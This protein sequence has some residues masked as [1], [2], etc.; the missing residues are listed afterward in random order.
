MAKFAIK[1]VS[2]PTISRTR[3]VYVMFDEG[4]EELEA[5]AVF[6][7]LSQVM[8]AAGTPAHMKVT[9]FSVWRNANW[10]DGDGYLTEWNS[11]DWYIAYTKEQSRE[12]QLHGGTLLRLLYSE[13]WQ[14]ADPHYDIVV[15]SRD[16]YDDDCHFCIGLAIRGFGTIISTNRFRGLSMQDAYNCIVTETMHE[17]GHVFGLVAE[18]RKS[19]VERSLGL[20]CTNR[21]IMR[22]GLRVPYDWQAITA[23]RLEGHEFCGECAHD[24]KRYFH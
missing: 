20:H 14:E 9:N 13:P 21:C 22:Q 15:T 24:L 8:I 19:N 11:V 16:L 5:Q 12:G 3:P 6:D 18:T 10:L 2:E 4:V 7:G 1:S 23:D 17:V